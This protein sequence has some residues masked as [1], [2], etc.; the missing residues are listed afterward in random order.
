MINVEKDFKDNAKER[1]NYNAGSKL[2]GAYILIHNATGMRYI[3]STRDL[4]HR[5]IKHE[6][7]LEKG[8]NHCKKLQELYKKEPSIGIVY[9]VTET[10]EKAYELEQWLIDYYKDSGM[11]LNIG[12]N[13]RYPNLGRKA[14]PE[15]TARK[16]L[17]RHTP[18]A[19]L[20]ISQG[21]M[22]RQVSAETRAKIG[23]ANAT[24]TRSPEL[25]ERLRQANLGTKYS[26]ERYNKFKERLKPGYLN[27]F[28]EAGRKMR[29]S[30]TVDGVEYLGLRNAAKYFGVSQPTIKRRVQSTS[31]TWIGW[32]WTKDVIKEDEE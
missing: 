4:Y 29:K 7:E 23:K 21:G 27:A 18:E 8:I 26:E 11:L 24:K 28:H 22:N 30:I 17:F 12:L 10:R 16:K 2:I 19:R 31:P 1:V 25:R 6:N 13:A 3:G 5:F 32:Q 9:Y 15:L 14:T 20:K